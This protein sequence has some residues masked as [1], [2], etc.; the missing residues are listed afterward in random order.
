MV[1]CEWWFR[2]WL[3]PAGLTI[4][5]LHAGCQRP[6]RIV[7]DGWD[8]R[9]QRTR[10]VIDIRLGLEFPFVRMIVPFHRRSA[11]MLMLVPGAAGSLFRIGRGAN[12][13]SAAPTAHSAPAVSVPGDFPLVKSSRRGDPA[14][15]G[16]TGRSGNPGDSCRM[17]RRSG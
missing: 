13:P 9:W 6:D 12:H 14:S 11:C 15:V 8:E 16:A 17:T 10:I 1:I 4:L 5:S 2:E 7:T 3:S